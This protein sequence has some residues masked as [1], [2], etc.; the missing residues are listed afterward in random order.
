MSESFPPGLA[1]STPLR[2]FQLDA[3]GRLD[4]DVTCRKCGY[5]LRGLSSQGV[6]TECGTAV[7]RSMMGDLLRFSDPQWVRSVASGMDWILVGILILILSTCLLSAV[8]KAVGYPPG[9]AMLWQVFVSIFPLV[10]Y[11]KLTNP[12]PGGLEESRLNSHRKVVRITT[13]VSFLASPMQLLVPHMGPIV[14]GIFGV[15]AVINYLVSTIALFTF[16]RLMALRIPDDKLA[17]NC[18]T[19]MWFMVVSLILIVVVFAFGAAMYTP[20]ATTGV[21]TTGSSGAVTGAAVTRAPI[22]RGSAASIGAAVG[23]CTFMV[24][25]LVAAIWCIVLFFRFRAA[26]HEA[27]RLAL[28]SWAATPLPRLEQSGPIS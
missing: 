11:W 2:Q 10:G 4:E 5:N 18:K 27:A 17:R 6:C 12:D 28:Q 16:A 9:Y 8:L 19:L 1:V 25:M 20:P 7:G 14:A 15:V 3:S 24:L 22:A 21:A 26:F 13:I 23:G